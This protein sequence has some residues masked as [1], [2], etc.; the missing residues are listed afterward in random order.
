MFLLV[1]DRLVSRA[2]GCGIFSG[3]LRRVPVFRALKNQN[4]VF[5]RTFIPARILIPG[6]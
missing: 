1:I 6:S 4:S 5:S 3:F 2:R